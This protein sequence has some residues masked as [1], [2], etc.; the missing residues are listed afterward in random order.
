MVEV[1][2]TLELVEGL[3]VG[4]VLVRVQKR[5]PIPNVGVSGKKG[6]FNGGNNYNSDNRGQPSIQKLWMRVFRISR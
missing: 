3:R 1:A 6:T 2:D 4:D 5:K